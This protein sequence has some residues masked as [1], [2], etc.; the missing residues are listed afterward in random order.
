[1]FYITNESSED[2]LAAT[3]DLLEAK[4]IARQIAKE[5]PVGELVLVESE[6]KGI[7]QLS[8]Q[9]NGQIIEYH[10]QTQDIAIS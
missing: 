10:I 4:Q 8:L 6:G 1:M 7:F 5:G 9:P 2:T 3:D